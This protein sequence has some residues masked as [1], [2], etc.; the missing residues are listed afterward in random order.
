MNRLQK[1]KANIQKQRK[2]TKNIKLN[3]VPVVLT[4]F[5][6]VSRFSRS[7]LSVSQDNFLQSN[8]CL[9]CPL[10]VFGGGGGGEKGGGGGGGGAGGTTV[11]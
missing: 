9:L 2:Q 10:T 1:L 11:K 7:G 3:R 8:L 5:Q 6:I 4:F